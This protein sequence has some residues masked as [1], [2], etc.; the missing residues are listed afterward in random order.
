M[1]RNDD[2]KIRTHL[3]NLTEELEKRFWYLTEKIIDPII[4]LARTHTSPSISVQ[5]YYA[6]ALI[7]LLQKR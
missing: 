3:E 7:A 5:F 2:F 6:W 4:E 1:H